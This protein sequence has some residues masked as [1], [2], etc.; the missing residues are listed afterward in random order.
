MVSPATSRFGL[1]GAAT[2]RKDAPRENRGRQVRALGLCPGLPSRMGGP[3]TRLLA[4][5][6]LGPPSNLLA[7][8]SQSVQWG[9]ESLLNLCSGWAGVAESIRCGNRERSE[10]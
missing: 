3:Q 5:A 2:D 8:T 10:F 4:P 6:L 1:G 9:Y 7:V